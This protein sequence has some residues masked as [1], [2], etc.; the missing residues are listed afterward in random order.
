MLVAS[1]PVNRLALMYARTFAQLTSTS[2]SNPI[3][4][5]KELIWEK[6]IG[7]RNVL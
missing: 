1:K 2:L 4:L 5:I 3:S 6:E 7:I